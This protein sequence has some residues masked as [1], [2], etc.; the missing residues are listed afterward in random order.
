MGLRWGWLEPAMTAPYV[1]A[2]GPVHRA[3]VTPGLFANVIEIAGTG[4]F[5]PH[6]KDR[7]WAGRKDEHV[8]AEAITAEP[9]L[10]LIP[11]LSTRRASCVKVHIYSQDPRGALSRAAELGRRLCEQHDAGKGWLAWFLPPGSDPDPVAACTRIQMRTFS[12]GQP[13]LAPVPG[14]VPLD[15]VTGPVRATFS[16]FAQKLAAEGFAFLDARIR[17]HGGTGP[18]L[19]CQRDGTIAGAI[20]PMEIMPDSCG[21]ARLLPQYFGVLPECRGL[22]LGRSPVAGRHALGAPAPGRP[23]DPA[24]RDRRRIRPPVPLRR[25]DRPR[26][27]LRQ[28]AL[29]PRLRLAGQVTGTNVSRCR[30]GRYGTPATRP[31]QPHWARL[32]ARELRTSG[33]PGDARSGHE[34]PYDL[35]PAVVTEVPPALAYGLDQQQAAPVLGILTAAWARWAPGAGRR[36]AVRAGACA[37]RRQRAALPRS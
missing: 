36:G 11:A 8:L 14:V 16:V 17:E 4:R 22:G 15:E 37:P 21:A 31:V 3:A 23:P 2:L 28:R 18:V 20:G 29:N 7:R 13:S 10:V 33:D 19:T 12:P 27:G 30:V 25:A 1:P 32:T 24:D 35:A 6:D 34:R 26:P 5:L 9:G